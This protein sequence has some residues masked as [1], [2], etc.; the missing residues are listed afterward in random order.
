MFHFL[1]GERDPDAVFH[2]GD[3]FDRDCYTFVSAQMSFREKDV[4]HVVARA[5]DQRPSM[6]AI[7]S[8][9]VWTGS[10]RRT[11]ISFRGTVSYVTVWGTSRIAFL[12]TTAEC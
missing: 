1:F 12:V 9:I 4:C 8:A 2:G 10:P 11:S 5:I 6:L 3:C 7:V